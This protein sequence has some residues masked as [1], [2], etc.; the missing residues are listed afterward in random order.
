MSEVPQPRRGAQ[1]ERIL[2]NQRSDASRDSSESGVRPVR[3]SERTLCS[4]MHERESDVSQFDAGRMGR[5]PLAGLLGWLVPGLGHILLG[6]R[7]RGLVCLVTI[8]ATFWCGVAIGGVR[9]TVD[10]GQRKLWF[11]AQLCTGA[12]TLA[13]VAV[14]KLAPLEKAAYDEAQGHWRSLDVA[15]H[16]TGVAGLL[17][18]LVLLD[19]LGRG[20]GLGRVR[21]GSPLVPGGSP[22]G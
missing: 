1:A 8:T 17:N 2:V 20:A 7:G 15:V 6:Y 21:H 4:V 11:L 14:T 5:L 18:V 3:R 9:T 22:G 12:N 16:Y 19:V 10:P 13:A